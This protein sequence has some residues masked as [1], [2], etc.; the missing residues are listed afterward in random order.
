[1]QLSLIPSSRSA[2]AEQPLELFTAAAADTK[3]SLHFALRVSFQ[4]GRKFC[5]TYTRAYTHTAARG[6]RL[7]PVP[8][9]EGLYPS[10]MERFRPVWKQRGC[11]VTRTQT[12]E[13]MERLVLRSSQTG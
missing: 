13:L 2:S 6:H 5:G 1:M 9:G 4:I 3:A 12:A 8:V 10:L 11:T 7:C